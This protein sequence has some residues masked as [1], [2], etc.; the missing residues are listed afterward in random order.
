[1][2]NYW[3]APNYAIKT[4]P[5]QMC[6]MYDA[7]R[8]FFLPILI[9]SG[10]HDLHN[11]L[12]RAYK[13]IKTQYT[14]Y[15]NLNIFRNVSTCT[16]VRSVIWLVSITIFYILHCT[17]LFILQHGACSYINQSVVN[18]DSLVLMILRKVSLP[19]IWSQVWMFTFYSWFVVELQGWGIWNIKNL[20]WK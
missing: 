12:N 16:F 13:Y 2:S 11:V 20:S 14:L 8:H 4:L 10:K 7:S 5:F 17:K 1:M 18:T 6:K 3:Q 15:H 19:V 9:S